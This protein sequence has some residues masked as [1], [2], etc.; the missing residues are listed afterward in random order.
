MLLNKTEYR[1]RALMAYHRS[2]VA[3]LPTHVH[4]VEMNG[5]NYVWL[6]DQVNMNVLAFYRVTNR[7][8]LKRMWRWPHPRKMVHDDDAMAIGW[9]RRLKMQEAA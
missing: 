6:D 5:L 7:G 2:G 3:E 9:G 4:F 8:A 1:L